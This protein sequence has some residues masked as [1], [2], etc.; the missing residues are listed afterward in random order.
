MSKVVEL[1]LDG[2]LEI[3]LQVHLAI[4][5]EAKTREV[6]VSGSLPPAPELQETY[7]VWQY[8]YRNLDASSR[9]S[10]KKITYDG[11]I[12]KNK[13]ELFRLVSQLK[14]QLNN[15]LN[16]PQF[17][18]IWRKIIEKVSPE[19][20]I[21]ILIRTTDKQLRKLPWHLWE[22]LEKYPYAEIALAAND[23]EKINSNYTTTEAKN[24]SILAI[25]GDSKGINIEEDKQILTNTL[26]NAELTFLCEPNREEINKKLWNY[27]WD[28]LFFAGH[29]QTE[30]ETG[31]IYINPEDSL[32][33]EEL[34]YAL[35]KAVNQGLKFAI[36]NSCD[37]LGLAN[38]FE[39]LNLP[40]IIVMR[41]PVPDLIA[42]Q[43]L[44]YFLTD[45]SQGKHFYLAV[46][47][48]R[49]RL[50]GLEGNYPGASWQPIIIQ[51]PGIMLPTWSSLIEV[52][53]SNNIVT[54]KK[55]S[56]KIQNNITS[57][58]RKILKY[59]SFILGSILLTTLLP[60]ILKQQL[61][62]TKQ[63]NSKF[64]IKLVVNTQITASGE[65]WSL[66]F[67]P[68]DKF[69]ASGNNHGTIEL[70]NRQT[71]D[72]TKI[73][74]EHPNVIRSL[75]F[76]S[77]TNQLISGDGDGNI[78]VWN[79]KNSNLETQL[80]GHSASIWDLAISPDGKTL[81]SCSQDESVRT[82]N[83]TTGEVNAILFSHETVVYALAFSP[84]GQF[85]ASAGKDK[86]IKIWNLKDRT[87]LKSFVG[88]EDAVRAIA[89]SP[90]GQYLVSGSWD[91]TVKVWDLE[92]DKLITT[93][94]GHQDRVVTIAI[95]QDSQFIFSG[96][97]DNTIK[98]WNIKNRKLI[99]T[100]TQHNNWI[101]ALAVS[102]KEN[103]L[104]SG[105]KEQK[106]KLWQY[107]NISQSYEV[108]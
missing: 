102:Q 94:I 105:G 95:S 90:N 97:I 8:Y 52:S 73:L 62:Q 48:A 108:Q 31:R 39:K 21:R 15:W 25:L 16:S 28:I 76:I 37:G 96:S 49:E 19:E 92:N 74:S 32:S 9:I 7:N 78:K 41:E 27:K 45:F 11:S 47:E 34:S 53:Q 12:Q 17:Q 33:L 54:T 89:I 3:G 79:R 2:T 65:V 20:T 68:D 10:A 98:V 44:K 42:Q 46:R 106:I 51:N 67:S 103:L 60:K 100:L 81:V 66:A 30:V 1:K 93:F 64:E 23:Y 86:I 58:R 99:T 5:P 13:T 85:F 80:M 59:G 77:Q 63:S 6:E 35:K 14:K 36:F 56:A 29:S 26:T 4:A 70:F 88:H 61:N 22:L 87:L 55:N 83:L 104:V 40:Q 71:G 72:I 107:Y 24:I 69:I 101:L 84:D 91:K 82:W 57:S 18:P 50:Q 43:F 38:F 75:V